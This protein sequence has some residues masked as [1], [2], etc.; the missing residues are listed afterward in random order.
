ML[1]EQASSATDIAVAVLVLVAVSVP[2]AFPVDAG[3]PTPGVLG[4]CLAAGTAVPLVW[5]RRAPFGCALVVAAFT[6]GSVF[7][8]RPGQP[9]QYG[10]A[11]AVY[12]VAAFGA[13]WQ[14]R[15][16]LAAWVSGIVVV[17][18]VA[19]D[20]DPVG[21]GFAVVTVVCAYG[22]G[23][24]ASI[25]REQVERAENEARRQ[26]LLAV[27]ESDRA[28]DAERRRIARDMHDIVAHAVSVM[29]VQAEAGAATAA[30]GT[31]ATP[32]HYDAISEA[33]RGAM[34]QLRRALSVLRDGERPD[35]LALGGSA[36]LTRVVERVEA[37]GLSVELHAPE[38]ADHVPAEIGVAIHRVVQESL[39]NTL[40]HAGA[41]SAVVDLSLRGD[42]LLLT[43]TDDGQSSA[44]MGQP[45]AGRGLIGIRERAAACGGAA[46]AGPGADGGF[47]VRVVLPLRGDEKVST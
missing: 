28:A 4:Y 7:Y 30:A 13:R 36:G 44:A 12:S 35:D 47:Q 46:D 29:I 40:R 33:G 11:V 18:F 17:S 25:G 6:V 16:L 20:R 26:G 3:A 8:D 21:I 24:L 39:T 15:G 27:L 9:F 37:A 42:D 23:R 5:R 14:R 2:F 22:L 41:T 43:I 19:G 1:A 34:E 31:P 10:A 32:A 45:I 38:L